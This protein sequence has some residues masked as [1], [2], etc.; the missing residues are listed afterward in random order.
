MGNTGPRAQSSPGTRCGARGRAFCDGE[1]RPGPAS[2]AWGPLW[3]STCSRPCAQLP[4]LL[5]ADPEF[6]TAP[7][8]A[9]YNAFMQTNEK[10]HASNVDDVMSGTRGITG[11]AASSDAGR[12]V[13]RCLSSRLRGIGSCRTARRAPRA[14]QSLTPAPGAPLAVLMR[15]RHIYVANVGDSRAVVS[16]RAP[17]GSLIA[18]DLS[19]DQTPYRQDELRRV[20]ACGA[21]VL[22]LDQLEGIKDPT[23]DCWTSEYDD[24]GDPPRLWLPDNMFPGTAFT[25]SIG[26]AIAERIGVF[27]EP[28][29]LIKKL[30]SRNRH[31]ILA[32]DG[33]FE[34]M[35]S[36]KVVDMVSKFTD[37]EEAC[38]AVC[39]ESY[40]LWLSNETRT[41]DI[42]I[43]LMELVG[44][45]DD[46]LPEEDVLITSPPHGVAPPGGAVPG[47]LGTVTFAPVE[48]NSDEELAADLAQI[49][50]DITPEEEELLNAVAM[51][52]IVLA[53]LTPEERAAVYSVVRR[54]KVKAG[55]AVISGAGGRGT[56]NRHLLARRPCRSARPRLGPG[57]IAL[58]FA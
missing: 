19:S 14:A 36:Q 47:A 3:G 7:H 28:E 30:T 11:G 44:L 29:V 15:G 56:G 21:V 31:I 40:R 27:A 8:I 2:T 48:G 10:L 41:D 13:C 20:R 34:F 53:D 16:E 12:P 23:M 32:S 33:V 49:A 51:S 5:Q 9:Y 26:D 42:T 1:G 4:V 17:D 38:V 24:D 58:G 54:Y 22:T 50:H 39:S 55:D 52:N 43:I 6:K 18:R 25:R 57:T 45:E 35:P 46:G 37:L